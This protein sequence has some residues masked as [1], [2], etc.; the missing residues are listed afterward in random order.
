MLL[1]SESL[2]NS[3]R[4]IDLLRIILIEKGDK[5]SFE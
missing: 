1:K 4:T 3:K 2:E 5:L